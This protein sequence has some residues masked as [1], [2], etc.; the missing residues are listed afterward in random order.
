M[1]EVILE[2]FQ[3]TPHVHYLQGDDWLFIGLMIVAITVAI[4]IS[5]ALGRYL[6]KN[7]ILDRIGRHSRKVKSC[8]LRWLSNHNA[9]HRVT[10]SVTRALANFCIYLLLAVCALG[11]VAGLVSVF[12]GVFGVDKTYRKIVS[13]RHYVSRDDVYAS[14]GFVEPEF[15]LDTCRIEEYIFCPDSILNHELWIRVDSLYNLSVSDNTFYEL[16]YLASMN[17][18]PQ[19]IQDYFFRQ[20]LIQARD[21]YETL[22]TILQRYI[23]TDDLRGMLAVDSLAKSWEWELG[24][25]EKRY[26]PQDYLRTKCHY[27]VVQLL[28]R[29]F[30]V[31][32]SVAQELFKYSCEGYESSC[33]LTDNYS[34][35]CLFFQDVRA[36]YAY[37]IH[38][39]KADKYADQLIERLKRWD[40]MFSTK[41]YLLSPDRGGDI[42]GYYNRFF[43]DPLFI[44]YKS[45]L[46]EKKYKK[47]ALALEAMSSITEDTPFDAD[48]PYMYVHDTLQPRNPS[49]VEELVA[50]AKYDLASIGENGRIRRLM[51]QKSAE[52]WLTGAY[53]TGVSY[54]SPTESI[55]GSLNEYAFNGD[56]YFAD[57]I[58][59][60]SINYNNTDPRWVYNTALFLKGTGADISSLIEES[61]LK[62][63]N[64][65][66][67][68]LLGTLK[69][70]KVF[71]SETDLDDK[72]FDLLDSLLRESFG[73]RI[74]DVLSECFYS[75]LDVKNALLDNECAIEIVKVPSL[76]FSDDHYKAVVVRKNLRRPLIFDLAPAS[77]INEVISNGN[78]YN[79]THKLYSLVW[80]PLEKT[81]GP[82]E[83]VYLAPDGALC[84]INFAAL[85]DEDDH[86]LMERFDLHQCVSTK[87]VVIH[88]VHKDHSSIALFG[89]V[90][91]DDVSH[92]TESHPSSVNRKAYRG[93]D[94]DS[95]G[96]GWRYLPGTRT[97]VESIDS[98]ASR[99][100]VLSTLFIGRDA[101]EHKF[102]SLTGNDIRILHIA[103]HGFY[104]NRTMASDLTFFE[105][106]V[107][108]DNPLNR[109]G[110][111]M[112]GG[113][114][115]WQGEEIPSSDEDGI[116]LGSEIARMDL[117]RVDMVVLSAC[118]TG[119]GDIT[120]E[121]VSGLQRAFKQAGVN[122][123][124]MTLSI[125]DDNATKM[126]MDFFYEMLFSGHDVRSA[127]TSSID[128]MRDE[129]IYN[130]PEY[131]APFVLL[132]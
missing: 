96:N 45:L 121:G 60:M 124:I 92:L 22:N 118:N 24:F 19:D 6:R 104:Y 32:D 18:F 131:W 54:L 7:G 52:D 38:E 78:L 27:Y 51:K 108:N 11:L 8:F 42:P 33:R 110:L 29:G 98:S 95:R 28:E 12:D 26:W 75:Y 117:T 36:R 79:G 35:I 14:I 57:L 100:G 61:V 39:P 119:L 73:N 86:R 2:D 55:F 50:Y 113:Q 83:T 88:K 94:C 109:C 49:R 127:F 82:N 87:D 93:V 41:S 130:D 23:V 47:A 125:V 46:R 65:N 43:T 44:R 107:L 84:S 69:T 62:T 66:L 111:I 76:D 64:D 101:T 34:Y 72:R 85:L 81:L 30:P 16:Y 4:L 15:E 80:K 77:I 9:L 91:Y 102:K 114:K 129:T 20:S 59:Y 68:T 112:T 10:Q 74:K 63:D 17:G 90:I 1:D 97:E 31:T 40:S 126:L 103:T 105:K 5:L 21:K 58:P 132:D 128:R 116:L 122:N 56:L 67:K 89:G 120:Y 99:H 37:Q 25:Y 3:A 70:E 123:I 106:M 53:L 71:V 13:K 48:N 115:A